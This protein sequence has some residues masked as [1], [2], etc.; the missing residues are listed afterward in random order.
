MKEQYHK[1]KTF[2][3]KDFSGNKRL[4]ADYEACTFIGCNFLEADFTLMDFIECQFIDC[5]LSLAKVNGSFFQDTTFKDCKLLGIQFDNCNEFGLSVGFESCVLDDCTF[6]KVKMPST[7]FKDC[8]LR[9][10][11]FT[12]AHL[13]GSSFEGSDLEA[14]VFVGSLLEKVDFR[15]ARHYQIDPERNGIKGAKFLKEH[16][17][18]LVHK[19]GL[20]LE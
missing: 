6:F 2:K 3:R 15:L 20:D 4:E 7:F 12:E 13:Q 1:E 18:G 8:Q 5:N 9:H 11:D 14:A 17:S 10:V 16:L 19:Y